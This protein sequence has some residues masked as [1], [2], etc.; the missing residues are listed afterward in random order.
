[1]RKMVWFL[2][3]ALLI[4]GSQAG[5]TSPA[6]VQQAAEYARVSNP[7]VP[8]SAIDEVDSV[9]YLEDFESGATGWTTMDLTSPGYMWHADNFNGYAGTNSWWCA[10][11]L[12]MGYNNHWLQYLVTPTLNFTGVTNPVL[13]FNMYY[14]VESPGGEP[15][16]YDGWDGCNVWVSVNGGTT[17]Q[18]INPTTP[19]YNC[20]N[21]Y[22]FGFEW[23]MGPGIAGWGGS[24]G[25]WVNASFNLAP[26][27]GYSNVKLRFAFCSD[28]AYC[29]IDNPSLYGFFVDNVLITAGA[30]TLLNNNADGTAIPGPFTY[31]TGPTSGDYWALST[32]SAHS[33]THSMRCNTTNHFSLSDAVVSPWLDIVAGNQTAF[34]FWLWCDMPD[35][36]GDG[37]NYLEDYYHIEVTTDEVIWNEVFYD[38]GDSTRPGGGIWEQY[39]PGMPFNGN[40]NLDLSAYAG[41]QI[42]LR[43]RVITDDN[44]DGGVGTG[45]YIDDLE[46]FTTGLQ[47]DVSAQKMKVPMPTS[48]YFDTIHCSVELHNLGLNAEPVVPAFYRINNGTAVPLAPWA[49][50][51]AGGMV[52]KNFNWVTPAPANFFFDSWTALGSDEDRS[53]DTSKAGMVELTAANVF[54][55]GYD[56]RQYSYEPSVYYFN[57]DAGEGAY[58]RY[59]PTSDGVNF[60]MNATS[61]KALFQNTGSIRVH[62]MEPGTASTPGPEVANFVATVTTVFPNWQTISLTN[63]AY[64]QNTHTD[65]W[66]WYET[67][68]AGAA[69]LMGWNDIVHGTGH[70]FANF[71]TGL[72]PSDYD[73]FA[74]AVFNGPSTSPNLTM[75]MTPT[76]SVSFPAAGGTLNYNIAGANNGSSSAT[77]DIWVNVTLPN[78]TY[79]GPVLGPVNNMVMPAGFSTNRDRTLTIPGSAPAGTYHLNGYMGDYSTTT[80]VYW[81]FDS[82]I[83][84]KSAD[85]NGSPWVGDWFVDS[86]E[87][88]EVEAGVPV[89]PQVYSLEQNFPNPFN[90]ATTLRFSLPEAGHV[91]LAVYDASGRLVTTLVEGMRE[92]GNHEVTFDAANLSSGVYLYR[93]QAGEF[94]A[95]GK[96]VL[97]K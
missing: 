49:N 37:D 61:L 77:V 56:N 84:T 74:R 33:P 38:Y 30:T 20:Q 15:P 9:Y 78:G 79:Y 34:R 83:F 2:F 21:L 96:M 57:F 59:T 5:A 85:L 64:L 3:C 40:L 68:T 51:P 65:F 35:W 55:F 8:S 70:F 19:A 29:T 87:P 58:I 47:H 82:F 89:L 42:K 60:N 7:L 80:P 45:L 26:L 32:A 41:Q 25:G 46:L 24:S 63:I 90:P 1:M 6:V 95:S 72:A 16:P 86:G 36:D 13:T 94:A 66:V 93:M 67:I 27:V 18:V 53:N 73:F 31:A 75:T 48:A 76:G 44:N 22:S 10:D 17:W 62:I 97:M 81:A 69:Q 52:M 11:P 50:I 43:W 14:A 92:A 54:E 91:T 23:G 4:F 28:P 12:L 88:F 39:L 71:G